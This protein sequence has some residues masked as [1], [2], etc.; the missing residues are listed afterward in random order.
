MQEK[1]KN[2]PVYV[3]KVQEDTRRYVQNL[4]K[5]NE[6]LR[7]VVAK[8]EGEK[9]AQQEELLIARGQLDRHRKEQAQL[10]RQLAE[11]QQENQQF[12]EEYVSI[13]QQNSNLANLYVASYRLHGTLDRQEVLTTIQEILVNLLGSEEIGIFELDP[14][15]PEL[16]LL[17]SCGIDTER[18]RSIAAADS[19][20]IGRVGL[21]GQPFFAGQSD[22]SADSPE[23]DNLTACIP[24]KVDGKITGTI[25]IFRLLQQK[26]GLEA[27]DYELLDLLATHAATA[28]YCTRLHARLGAEV[29]ATS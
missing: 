21:S 12:S 22:S 6:T 25:A 11:I 15:K 29:G 9:R 20:L 2:E 24:L 7:A 4:L 14:A 27:L 28:L 26:S 23:Q 3:R 19:G 18:Y 5:E 8:M 16:R 13:E 10:Q 1:G 17:A